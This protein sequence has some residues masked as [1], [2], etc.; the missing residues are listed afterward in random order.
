MYTIQQEPFGF[1]LVFKGVVN[2]AEMKEWRRESERYLNSQKAGFNVFVNMQDLEPLT[3]EAQAVME[4]GQRAYRNHGMV[5]S[6]VILNNTLI[7]LQFKR[8]AK[9]SGIYQWERYIDAS[10]T[11]DWERRGINWLV[12]GIDPDLIA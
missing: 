9:E 12:E 3:A 10:V 5:R 2:A 7:T 4:E 11:A 1:S 8:I 6:V